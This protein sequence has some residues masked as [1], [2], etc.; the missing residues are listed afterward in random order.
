MLKRKLPEIKTGDVIKYNEDPAN[1]EDQ[2]LLIVCNDCRGLMGYPIDYISGK[3]QIEGD[4]IDVDKNAVIELYVMHTTLFDQA[5]LT[6]ILLDD[7]EPDWDNYL[8]VTA[9]EVNEKFGDRVHVVD[10]AT[11]RALEFAQ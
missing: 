8:Y 7:I 6:S 11:M 2:Y 1:L 5:Y 10:D 9:Y 3:I 4:W